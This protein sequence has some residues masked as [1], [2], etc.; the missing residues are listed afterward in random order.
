M[1][2]LV[3]SDAGGAHEDLTAAGEAADEPLH[4]PLR[5]VDDLVGNG[6]WELWRVVVNEFEL[7]LCGGGSA[8]SV[9]LTLGLRFAE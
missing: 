2:L 4:G 1:L 5:L 3:G 6:P 9:S 7:E 8:P